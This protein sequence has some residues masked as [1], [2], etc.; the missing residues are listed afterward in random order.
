MANGINGRLRTLERLR[1]QPAPGCAA[2]SDWTCEIVNEG[3]LEPV[4]QCG[5][6][7]RSRP[8]DMFIVRFVTRD[9]GPQ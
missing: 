3:D 4:Q 7:G 6:C 5:A 8:A 1:P 9:D 2:C